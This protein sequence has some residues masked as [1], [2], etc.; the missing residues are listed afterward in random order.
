MAYGVV[1]KG[2]IVAIGDDSLFTLADGEGDEVIGFA[3]EGGR[4]AGRDGGDHT[5]QV[6]GIDRNF[7][8]HGIT[9]SVWGLRNRG[10][11]HYLGGSA[12]QCWGCLRHFRYSTH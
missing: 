2:D 9:D 4:H 8:G 6:E 3:L 5:F 10:L 11:P 7:S 1:A 12:R